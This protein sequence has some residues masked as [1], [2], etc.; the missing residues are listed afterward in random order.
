MNPITMNISDIKTKELEQACKDYQVKSLYVFGSTA[1][2]GFSENS[3]LDFLV[4]FYRNGYKGAFDQYMG[5]KE[6]LEKI[7][8]RP[9]DL[10]TLKEFRNPVFQQEVD[11]SKTLVY[12]A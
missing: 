8:G 12:A 11:E 1:T 3:D 7:Y 5:F 9:V 6:R 4:E 10:V 2:G